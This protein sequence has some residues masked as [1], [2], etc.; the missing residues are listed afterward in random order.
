MVEEFVA[1]FPVSAFFPTHKRMALIIICSDYERLR[2]MEGKEGFSDLPEVHKDKR[3]VE[4]GLRRLGFAK[5]DIKRIEN[6]DICTL[7]LETKKLAIEVIQ[8]YQAGENTLV[9]VYYAGHACQELFTK[10]ILNVDSG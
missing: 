6:P 9:Y 1:G 8:N 2:E 3:V 7:K 5:S 4:A 10:V